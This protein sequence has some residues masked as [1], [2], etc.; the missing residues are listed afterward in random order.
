MTRH[1]ELRHS[2]GAVRAWLATVIAMVFT[3]VVVGGI[4]RLTGSGLSMVEW[5][6]I[7]GIVPPLSDADWNAAFEA[8]KQYPQYRLT[9]PDM[10]LDG[11]KGIFFWEYVHR[12]L[13]RAIGMA[14]ALPFFWFLVRG[15]FE[16]PLAMRLGVALLLGGTQGFVGWLMVKSGLVDEPRVSHFRLAAHLGLALTIIGYLGW[17]L[18]SLRPQVPDSGLKG[19]GIPRWALAGVSGLL[20]LQILYGAFVAGLRAGWGYN[21]FPRMGDRWIADAVLAME[22]WWQGLLQDHAT[23]QFVHRLLGTVLLGFVAWVW[24]RFRHQARDLLQQRF[25]HL[26]F[27]LVIAQYALGVYTLVNVVPLVP[28]VMHQGCAALVVLALVGVLSRA[29]Q[30][31]PSAA[32]TGALM[33]HPAR[34]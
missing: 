14:F 24:M 4:T 21:T 6:P 23:V 20:V 15:A 22:P 28:A 10:D 31:A 9:H 26:L 34:G 17:V 2:A 13:G 5:E 3:M 12:V 11:F 19:A 18:L 29:W 25:L 33:P 8:Y 32:P 1:P 27:G 7:M 16:R 30:D